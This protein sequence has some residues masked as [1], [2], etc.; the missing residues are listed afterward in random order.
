MSKDYYSILG[1]GKGAS[2]EEIKKAYRKAAMQWHP[3]K[4]PNNP[5]AE[6]KFKE[7]AEAYDVLS[8]PEKKSNFDRF[9]TADGGFG[10]GNPF[11]SNFGHGFN[12][13][14]IFSQFGDIFGNFG[15]GRRQQQ[16][17]R[18]GQDLRLKINVTIDEVINGG[19]KKIR[20]KRQVHCESCSGK[21]GTNVKN[22]LPCNGSGQR[23]VV[24]NTP[25]GQI[26][27]QTTCPDC[28]GSGRQIQDLCRMCHGAGTEAKDQ[29]VEVEIPKGVGNGMQFTMS[30]FGNHIKDGSP[31]DL[32]ILIEEV[33]EFYFK[34]EGPNLTVNKEISVIDA[35]LGNQIKVRTPH[36]E[37]PITIDPGT[38]SGRTIRVTGKGV[39]DIN[40]GTGDLFVK[41]E[42]K[43]PKI[44]SP[45]EKEILEKL[46]TSNSF[47]A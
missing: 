6:A 38:E 9:G 27:T 22:C 25:F 41:V 4:N 1:V 40:Y 5:E 7:A 8:N 42:V 26:K 35:I 17:R 23:V 21:G 18:R 3:D 33:Q 15:G 19:T 14:D 34:R 20:Y 2:D 46:R 12:M 45:E 28:Q 36:G 44:I 32:H 47:Q 13:D 43:I 30:G 11:G 10:G 31:G 24:Q 16:Q 39:P 37:I 29:T